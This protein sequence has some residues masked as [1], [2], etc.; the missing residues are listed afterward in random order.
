VS[1]EH[2]SYQQ[3]EPIHQSDKFSIRQKFLHG[4]NSIYPPPPHPPHRNFGKA[5]HMLSNK[6]VTYEIHWVAQKTLDTVCLLLNI[7][8]QGVFAV[9]STWKCP[10]TFI[11][12]HLRK[13]QQQLTVLANILKYFGSHRP[14][15]PHATNKEPRVFSELC[16]W[17][18]LRFDVVYLTRSRNGERQ[19]ETWEL[20]VRL[21]PLSW[22]LSCTSRTDRQGR[23]SYGIISLQREGNFRFYISWKSSRRGKF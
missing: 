6:H 20:F 9:L 4:A 13:N 5:A 11:V 17:P 8:C 19:F 1:N 10:F 15:S 23:P 7:A 2:F 18:L 14:W 21:Q 12:W 16:P 22:W 3:T